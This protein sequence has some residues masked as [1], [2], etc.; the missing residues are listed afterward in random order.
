MC[1]WEFSAIGQST[2]S[3]KGQSTLSTE[4]V[5]TLLWVITLLLVSTLLWG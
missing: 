5:S 4:G 3:A 1:L 2:Y